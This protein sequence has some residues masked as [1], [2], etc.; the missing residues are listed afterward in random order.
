M[1]EGDIIV[2]LAIMSF[3][4]G[5][6]GGAIAHVLMKRKSIYS[7][8]KMTEDSDMIFCPRCGRE[9]TNEGMFCMWC[10]CNISPFNKK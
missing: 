6:I 10:G 1:T 3:G 9:T 5:L 2:I 8:Q 4:I 7:D